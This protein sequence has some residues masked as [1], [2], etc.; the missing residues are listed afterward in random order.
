MQPDCAVGEKDEVHKA[1]AIMCLGSREGWGWRQEEK[2]KRSSYR[3]GNG[4]V[5]LRPPLC[6]PRRAGLSE[7]TMSGGQLLRIHEFHEVERTIEGEVTIQ[8]VTQNKYFQLVYL[9]ESEFKRRITGH[10][11]QLMMTIFQ[12]YESY[13]SSFITN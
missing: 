5:R 1:S 9:D 13:L 7:P 11:K 8:C 12:T 6:R 2:E 4:E 10:Q 3:S